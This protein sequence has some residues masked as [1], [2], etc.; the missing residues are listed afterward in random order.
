MERPAVACRVLA[1]DLAVLPAREG[2][3]GIRGDRV[4]TEVSGDRVED[5]HRVRGARADRGDLSVYVKL[6][7][8]FVDATLAVFSISSSDG[9]SIAQVGSACG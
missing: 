3:R 8:G 1:G 5:L 9:R 2:G 4:D 7:S 6:A